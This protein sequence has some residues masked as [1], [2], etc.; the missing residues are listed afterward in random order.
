MRLR[1]Q[2]THRIGPERPG[3]VNTD[4]L[5]LVFERKHKHIE[6]VEEREKIIKQEFFEFLDEY[7]DVNQMPY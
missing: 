2:I 7:G 6:N 5:H 4:T 1:K 3:H